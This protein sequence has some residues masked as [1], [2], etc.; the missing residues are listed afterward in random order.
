MNIHLR[1]L[2]CR[3]NQAEID[4]MARQFSASGHTLQSAPEDA[5]LLVVNTC[6][7]TGEAERKSRRLIRELARKAPKG[8]LHVTGC[9]A[10]LAAAEL[11]QLPGVV[12]VYDNQEKD[13]LV[14]TVTETSL[15]D[16]EPIQREHYAAFSPR[17]R[18]FVKVQDGC[19]HA[20]TFCITTIVRG[21]SRSRSI[22]EVVAEI[23]NLHVAGF[24]EVVL[25]GVQLGSYGKDGEAPTDLRALVRAILDDTDIERLRLSSLEP[26]DLAESFFS[27]WEDARLCRHL[28]LPLQSGCDA[29]LRRMRRRTRQ[30]EYEALLEQARR[31]IPGVH[32][33]SDIIVGFPGETEAEFASSEAFIQDC[34][35]ASMHVFRYSRRTGT[36]AA[37]MKEQVPPTAA[38]ERSGRLQAIAATGRARY[39]DRF[40]GAALP[41]LWEQIV[42]ATEHGFVHLGYTEN[43][44]PVRGRFPQD[45][46]QTIT[47]AWICG[48]DA[49][50]GRALVQLES[51]KTR[52]SDRGALPS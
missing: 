5:D 28:H 31:F 20:C 15:E 48:Y 18:A 11:S 41:V 26:W 6:A 39:A 52:G 4:A 3:L 44:I 47:P 43:Y 38:R 22:P 34:N 7:V 45:L 32:I 2:G 51:A 24:R 37:R 17:T 1:M 46:T 12:R 8:A 30:R 25:T 42:G 13:T 14:S 27:L 49:K 10:Q 50:S 9:Y 29:T 16:L 40:M 33:S 36:P 21:A 35:F 19:D 23:Q